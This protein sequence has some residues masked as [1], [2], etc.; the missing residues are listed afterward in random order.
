M[1][2]P[3]IILMIESILTAITFI[4]GLDVVAK[5]VS[6]TTALVVGIFAIRHYV[7]QRKLTKLQIEK[8][9]KEK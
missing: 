8:L 1:F 4:D 5:I 6:A 3:R 9:K 2:S 7:M